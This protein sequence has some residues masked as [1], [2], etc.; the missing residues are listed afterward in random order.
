[1][2]IF[3]KRPLASIIFIGLGG[4]LLFALDNI[5]IRCVLVCL[6]LLPIIIPFI[7]TFFKTK[8]NI[9]IIISVVLFLSFLLSYLYFD[10]YFYAYEVY[11]NEIEVVGVVDEVAASSS[12]KLR[13]KIYVESINGKSVN[14]YTFYAYP[15]K[16]DAKG[17]IDGTRISFTATLGGFSDDSR[18]YNI[19]KGVNAYANDIDNIEIIEY[20]DDGI[21]GWLKRTKETLSRYVISISDSESGA[22]LSAL[23]LGEKEHLSPK[24]RLDFRKIGISHILALSGMHLAILSL[25][26]DKFLTFIRIKKKTRVAITSSLVL[27]YMAITGF[28]VSVCRAGIMLIISSLLFLLGRGKDSITSLSVAVLVICITNPNAIFDVSLWL[29]ALATFGIISFGE[30]LPK[31]ETKSDIKSKALK[32]IKLALLTSVYAISAT[33]LISTFTFDGFSILAPIA[34]LLFSALAE[35]IMYLGCV[36]FLVGWLIPL[37]WLVSPLTNLLTWLADAFSSIKFTYVSSNFVLA[38]VVIIIYSLF[39]F[40]FMFVK[41]KNRKLFTKI[42]LLLYTITLLVPTVAT[43]YQS[44]QETI[45]YLGNY[46]SDVILIRSD[47]E[48]CVVNSSQY[49]KSTAYDAIEIL[50][51]ANVTHLDKYYLTHYS[52][53]LDEDI[54]TLLSN[55]SVD[56]IYI[57]T[58]RNDDE[59]TILKILIKCVESTGATIRQYQEYESVY[60][61]KYK[62]NLLYSSPYG[63]TSMN[64]VA[65]CDRDT[66]YTYISSGLLSKNSN[67]IFHKYISLSDYII[68]GDHGKKYKDKIYLSDC[69]EDLDGI[70]IHSDNIFLEQKNY[71]FF[72]E[73]E[74]IVKTH[75]E[76]I[77]YLPRKN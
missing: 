13:L 40:L 15:T 52:W 69:Y 50:E 57:P 12:Y 51:D 42:L 9:L 41:V 46:K 66:I 22:L 26:L 43:A 71:K 75:T 59:D 36:M 39:F 56:E 74:C 70:I 28:S 67:N 30:S 38:K 49:S 14:D 29:S 68:L 53:S 6:A 60:V 37:G 64:A 54:E 2:N 3:E 16:T 10:N 21:N 32:Y 33:M 76:E 63:E 72:I 11:K 20:T 31:E 8:R 48:A 24:L 7:F 62:I 25:G 61:G 18:I 17:I 45:S 23:L 65:I 19:S 55:V 47:Y 77:I 27:L 58:P 4:F 73:N 5:I 34:T 1:M 44:S 35:I